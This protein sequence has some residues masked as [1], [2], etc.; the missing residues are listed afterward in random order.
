MFLENGAC[1]HFSKKFTFL[2]NRKFFEIF[3]VPFFQFLEKFS[4]KGTAEKMKCLAS[5]KNSIF[6]SLI[7]RAKK[8]T[9]M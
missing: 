8:R 6:S 9:L 2:E 3:H 1:P 7:L 4:K 5:V